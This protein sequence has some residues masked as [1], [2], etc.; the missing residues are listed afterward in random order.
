V[1]SEISSINDLSYF[2]SVLFHVTYL[3]SLSFKAISKFFS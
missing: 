1:S 2:D 3:S